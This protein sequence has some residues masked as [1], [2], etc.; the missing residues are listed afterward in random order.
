VKYKSL[1]ALSAVV[2]CAM[3]P[4]PG[5]A[6]TASVPAPS[7]AGPTRGT[8]LGFIGISNVKCNCTFFTGDDGSRTF[9][10]RSNP[11]VLG[12][13]EGSPADGA[14]QR[15]DTITAIDGFQLMTTEGARRFANV[16]PG[17]KLTLN[18]SRGQRRM[19]LL[20]K[21]SNIVSG[22]VRAFGT[23]PPKV[24]GTWSYDYPT[25][26]P[27]ATPIPAEPAIPPM[28]PRAA[29]APLRGSVVWGGRTPRAIAGVAAPAIPAAPAV[30][31]VAP[32]APV[33][34]IAAVPAVAPVPPLPP[35][36]TGWF[37][38]SI[39]CSECGWSQQRDE[40]SPVWESSTP[41]EL[42]MISRDGPAA[43]AGLL[44]GDRITHV[45]GVSILTSQ[46]ARAFGRVRPGQKVRLTV[47]RNGK[48]LTRELT[49]A[50]RPELR[51]ALAASASTPRPAGL[52]RELRYTGQLDNVSVEVWSA[53]GPT[54][55]RKG[56][57]ITITVGTSVIRL[58]AR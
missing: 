32:T 4:A 15:G 26:P 30:T 19:T 28:A 40:D 6:Q 47:L 52:R 50:T 1:T 44:A 39:K 57:T 35:S 12:I 43:R 20:L 17:Q 3:I 23:R 14:L 58:K 16:Q 13:Y 8:T 36:P 56:D 24:A 29:T 41:P 18:V 42:S 9:T 38:F 31:A 45:N 33:A 25:P 34:A 5:R 22:D 37:G 53:A 21:A 51:A 27:A 10:F 2:V 11:V 54:I 46:G 48:S 7:V 49:L 55:D